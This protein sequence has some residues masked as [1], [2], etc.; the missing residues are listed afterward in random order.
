MTHYIKKRNTIFFS[1]CIHF[2]QIN[3]I[4]FSEILNEILLN[5]AMYTFSPDFKNSQN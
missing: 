4:F 1:I 2:N 3:W 5:S